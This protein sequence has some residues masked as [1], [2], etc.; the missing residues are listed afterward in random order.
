MTSQNSRVFHRNAGLLYHQ[1]VSHWDIAM[2]AVLR[3]FIS[4]SMTLIVVY[5][6]GTTTGVVVPVHDPAIMLMGWLYSGWFFGAL[7]L[8]LG[9]WTEYWEPAE[10]FIQPWMYIMLPFSG[11][12]GLVAWLPD[13]AQKVLLLCPIVHC[14]EMFRAGYFGEAVETHYSVA[15][16]TWWSVGLTAVAAGAIHHVRERV[17]TY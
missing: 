11:A 14:F 12:F 10:K 9:A 1:P 17:Q 4:M 15:Y 6:V 7:G 3:E 13:Y 2:A 8:T 16:L 5:F